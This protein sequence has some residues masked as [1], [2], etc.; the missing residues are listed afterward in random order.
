[1]YMM[2]FCYGIDKRRWPLLLLLPF[3][4]AAKCCFFVGEK[5]ETWRTKKEPSTEKIKEGKE[6]GK[7]VSRT[8]TP[9][10]HTFH[11]YLAYRLIF[12]CV[13]VVP[14][15]TDYTRI[16]KL[17]AMQTVQAPSKRKKNNT[18]KQNNRQNRQRKKNTERKGEK[19]NC[20][21]ARWKLAHQRWIP[22]AKKKFEKS[23]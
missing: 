23:A 3:L 7:W 19:S 8:Q 2:I 12:C 20:N 1:M 21:T 14:L 13:Q 16:N 9:Q 5:E 10:S 22:T 11:F 17:R 6:E 4:W 18:G 15:C